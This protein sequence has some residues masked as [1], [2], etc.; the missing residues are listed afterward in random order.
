MMLTLN[1]P[2][3][4]QGAK[5]R[6]KNAFAFGMGL[7][8]FPCRRERNV[9]LPQRWRRKLWGQG[10]GFKTHRSDLR[11]CSGPTREVVANHN[12]SISISRRRMLHLPLCVW[13]IWRRRSGCRSGAP[14]PDG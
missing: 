3:A 6:R 7:L 8:L 14:T 13:R 12:P 4:W 5:L 1:L 10:Y 11:Y 9:G 2:R